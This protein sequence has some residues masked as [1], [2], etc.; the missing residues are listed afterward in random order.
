MKA[1]LK[2]VLL[3]FYTNNC[4]QSSTYYIGL[5]SNI[6]SANRRTHTKKY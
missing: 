3:N 6:N 1:L 4:R 5:V 2:I